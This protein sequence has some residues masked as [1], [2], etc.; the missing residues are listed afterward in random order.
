MTF[1]RTP[2]ACESAS[3]SR[4]FFHHWRI[5][6]HR[7]ITAVL[8]YLFTIFLALLINTAAQAQPSYEESDVDE[9][10][11]W[12]LTLDL[13]KRD[14]TN[15][16]IDRQTIKRLDAILA[17]VWD[18]ALI[19]RQQADAEAALQQRLLDALKPPPQIADAQITKSEEM[20]ATFATLQAQLN[21][22][23]ARA[24]Q[25]ALVL[26]RIAV[27][28]ERM[29]AVEYRVL[30]STLTEYTTLPLTAASLR[31]AAGQ[32]K[33]RAITLAENV[34]ADWQ[35]MLTAPERRQRL[36]QII[37][38]WLFSI[39]L[40]IA[41]HRWLQA[42]QQRRYAS[43][44]P[45]LGNRL[46]ATLN[47][48]TA[49]VLLPVLVLSILIIAL[50]KLPPLSVLG[51]ITQGVL[52]ELQHVIVVIGLAGAILTPKQTLW[53]I[54]GFTD[55]AAS[56]LYRALRLYVLIAFAIFIAPLLIDPQTVRVESLSGETISAFFAADHELTSGIGLLAVL[57]MSVLLLNVLRPKHWRFAELTESIDAANPTASTE[58][59]PAAF[60]RKSLAL[61]RLLLL[62][63]VG[64]AVLGYLNA[65]VYLLDRISGTLALVS[66]ALLLRTLIASALAQLSDADSTVGAYLKQRLALDASAIVRLVFWLLLI[67]DIVLI[68]GVITLLALY[69]GLPL[70]E[71]ERLLNAIAVGINLGGV[72]LTLAK[73][74]L[75]VAIFLLL[76][77]AIRLLQ[78][79]LANRV[80]TQTRLD[81]GARDALTAG[82]G[83]LGLTIAALIAISL[84]GL[85]FSHLALIL[86]A[87]SVGIG[88]GLQ[89]VVNNFVSGLILLIQ[90]PIKTG[91]WIVIGNHQG[92]VKSIST[93]STEIQTFDNASVI[94]PNSNLLSQQVMNWTHKSTIGRAIVAVGVAY[95]TDPKQVNNVLLSCAEANPNVLARP[96]PR[97]LLQNFGSS[98]L[99]FELRFY[100]REID[101]VLQVASDLRVAIKAE[102]DRVGIVIAFPQ[103]DIH[104]RD[105]GPWLP[106]DQST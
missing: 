29:A 90:R 42:G 61:A 22:W 80:L 81:S 7:C 25:T 88:F 1:F 4:A 53:R 68:V 47:T 91:D 50:A 70:I 14:I 78:R 97:V 63:S 100:I 43:A 98:S 104:L 8:V 36:L 66:M 82:V 72:R 103:Q 52:E 9:I 79:F 48:I 17:R 13:V 30:I 58:R 40:A 23:H 46:L 10:K 18:Q 3:H 92:Y 31:Q 34:I 44:A 71:L 73:I 69:W 62:A 45:T 89:H 77:T 101:S 95:D 85:D 33:Q 11:R 24:Q 94:V 21:H 2:K 54:I 56:G 59:P 35:R 27:L 86:G 39:A 20:T 76:L 65:G 41:L 12:R 64:L 75:A 99:D 87:L 74:G 26:A 19:A 105:V 37:G 60:W 32:L 28:R 6:N 38:V 96:E 84:L 15:V 102:F 49:N 55:D 51:D 106:R 5:N 83:Y 57:I 67:L 16:D 93:I